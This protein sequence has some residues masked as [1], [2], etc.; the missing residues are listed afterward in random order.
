MG[1][2]RSH[3]RR[4]R[5]RLTVAMTMLTFHGLCAGNLFAKNLMEV[6]SFSGFEL[7][8]RSMPSAASSALTKWACNNSVILLACTIWVLDCARTAWQQHSTSAGTL[9]RQMSVRLCSQMLVG[10][11]VSRRNKRIFQW[12]SDKTMSS[13]GCA[14]GS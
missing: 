6:V 8:A 12:S 13:C 4:T 3:Q 9:A 11:C 10:C 5:M 7:I 2:M 1:Q 14:T